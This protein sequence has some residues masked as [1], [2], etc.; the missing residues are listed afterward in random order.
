[1][2]ADDETFLR[3]RYNSLL[4]GPDIELFSWGG[5]HIFARALH[6]RFSYPIILV[7]GDDNG[8]SHIYCRFSDGYDY[9]VDVLGFTREDIRVYKQLLRDYVTP[10]SLPDLQRHETSVRGPGLFSASWFTDPAYLKA[11]SRI[12]TYLPYFDGTLRER[13]PDAT[14]FTR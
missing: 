9:C 11:R 12:D 10:I 4:A 6:D 3:D 7:P 13:V 5:C 8:V 1:M 14:H 2:N